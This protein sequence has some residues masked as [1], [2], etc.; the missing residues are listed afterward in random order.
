MTKTITL[1][2]SIQMGKEIITELTIGDPTLE[3]LDDVT[4]VATGDGVRFNLGDLHKVIA[5]LCAIPPA[6]A[7]K[8]SIIDL[9]TL[10]PEVMDFLGLSLPTGGT[11]EPKSPT[12]ST[13]S[14]QN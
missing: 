5:G 14:P 13:S 11:S 2:K 3:V 10:G 4:I 8:I 6:A 9:A 12:S 1:K 7:K